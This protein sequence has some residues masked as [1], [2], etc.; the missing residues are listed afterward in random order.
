MTISIPTL[1]AF[2]L[3]GLIALYE[4]SVS[5]YAGLIN[6]NAYHQPGVEAGKKA[7]TQFLTI[8]SKVEDH[9]TENS[10]KYLTTSE[11]ANNI[12][13]EEEVT[14]HALHHLSSNRKEVSVSIGE[15]PQLDQFVS[16]IN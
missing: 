14:F 6:I 5:Y 1:N 13:E 2:Y 9:L 4:R 10:G 7:A 8:L 3:G 15:S 11:V 12:N 16:H